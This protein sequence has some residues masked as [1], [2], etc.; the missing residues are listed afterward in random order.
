MAMKMIPSAR[1]AVW[2]CA[3]ALAGL[4]LCAEEAAPAVELERIMGKDAR[5]WLQHLQDHEDPDERKLAIYCLGEFGAAAREAVGALAK[6]VRDPLDSEVR[7]FAM[8]ALGAIGPDA[9]EAI[10]PLLEVLRDSNQTVGAKKSACEALGKIDPRSADVLKALLR[11]SRASDEAL[12]RAAAD[13]LVT[14]AIETSSREALDRLQA[15]LGDDKDAEPIAQSVICMGAQGASLLAETL[16]R[17]REPVA[18][19]AAAEALGRMGPDARGG[20]D[21]LSKAAKKDRDA[22]VKDAATV[23][24]ARLATGGILPEDEPP[25]PPPTKY[26]VEGFSDDELIKLLAESA[27]PEKRFESVMVLRGRKDRTEAAAAALVKALGDSDLKVKLA[28]AKSLALFGEKGKEA[29]GT[30]TDWLGSGEP[31]IQRAAMAALAGIG[32][33]SP[34]TLLVLQSLA[35]SGAADQDDEMRELL[36]LALRAQ[37][38]N[39]ATWLTNAL[40]D[41]D[42]KVRLR[43]VKFLRAM[44]VVALASVPKLIEEAGGD[45]DDLAVAALDAI[46]SMGPAIRTVCGDLLALLQD[47]RPTRREHAALALSS[48]G[49]DK[50]LGPKVIERL[51]LSLMDPEPDVCRGA[52]TSLTIIGDSVLPKLREIVK[53]ADETPFWVLRVMARLKADPEAVIPRMMKLVL[54]G[55]TPQERSNAAEL[56]GYYAPEH[57]EIVPVLVRVLKDRDRYLV[58]AATFSLVAYGKESMPFLEGAMRSRDP[59]MRRNAVAALAA[60]HEELLKKKP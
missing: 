42:K 9:S 19:R 12:R 7:R 52:H 8:D 2:L 1:L 60:V 6:F 53:V 37:G 15:M 25:P 59:R 32:V 35:K 22:R 26:S 47:P 36:G 50:D 5:G 3:I 11:E 29:V 18:R 55:M 16:A 45:D 31:G 17:S 4:R 58:Q 38:V 46:G 24:L 10:P 33:E 13:A 51:S 23:A 34:A 30:L 48:V 56:L 40:D 14:V 49:R 21:A 54:P 44:G 28:A 43:A 27:D 57:K 41:P 20:M 39:A